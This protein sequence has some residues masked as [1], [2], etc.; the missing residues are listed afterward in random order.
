MA[1]GVGTGA[2][3]GAFAEG[4]S[5]FFA[6]KTAASVALETAEV[7]G[8]D[9]GIEMVDMLATSGVTRASSSAGQKAATTVLSRGAKL[10]ATKAVFN[11]G[12]GVLQKYAQ[13]HAVD[14]YVYGKHDELTGEQAGMTIFTTFVTAGTMQY[15]STGLEVMGQTAEGQAFKTLA[16]EGIMDLVP[17]RLLEKMSPFPGGYI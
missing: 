4:A 11:S 14:N 5:L 15:K 13:I 1:I 16:E 10:F 6:A 9:A 3:T 8:E 17:L 12:F 7:V 2:I